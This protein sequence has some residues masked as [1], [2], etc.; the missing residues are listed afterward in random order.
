M[1]SSRYFSIFR[2]LVLATLTALALHSEE[3]AAQNAEAQANNPLADITAFNIQN[4]YID[5]FT[6]PGNQSGN[7][8]VLRYAKPVQWGNSKWLIRASLPYN[9]FPVGTGGSTVN[10]IG[11]FDIF[12]AY[13]IDT[14]NPAISFAVG[15]QVVAP[16][17]TDNRLGSDQ[18]QLGIAN[19][20]FNAT[21]PKF[22]YGYL[23]TWRGGVGD[24]KGGPRV[25]LGAFQP[26]AF[27]QLGNGWYTGGAP[28]WTYNFRNNNYSVP[29]GIR[30][31]K[32]VKRDKT[33]FNLFVEPQWSVRD[34]GAGQPKMQV[35][36]ALNMQFL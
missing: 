12:A 24:T 14:G 2:V 16:T 35:Y 3:A 13:Q 36:F 9:S 20:Y 29:L 4:Y 26:F 22:Q 21:S 7:Q 6:G 15:P 27:Y 5:E 1:T 19:V 34:K 31:G 28:I 25:S 17:A 18:W 10:G 11:D 30:L 32:V 33:V 23:L 8:F